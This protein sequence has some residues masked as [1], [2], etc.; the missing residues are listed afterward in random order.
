MLEFLELVKAPG[1]PIVV[2]DAPTLV[3]QATL[4][5]PVSTVPFEWLKSRCGVP[6]RYSPTDCLFSPGAMAALKT[7]IG[8]CC[9]PVAEE[10]RVKVLIDR[11]SARRRVTN[12]Q[13][14]VRYFSDK[15]Y[16]IAIPERMS[17]REQ[18]DLFSKASVIVGQT[19]AGLANMLFS[20]SGARIIV[21]SGH[22]EDPGPHNYFPNI[23]RTLG[24]EVQFMAFGPP[25]PNLHIDFK[26]DLA[27]LDQ[28]K[29]ML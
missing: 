7:R 26:V 10:D 19:G 12:R 11:N 18:M 9:P 24:H 16:V 22:P 17:L 28:F 27:F 25:S 5:T 2:I 23:A 3:E 21:L 13:E 8:E 4:F 6:V 1:R 14:L 15:G 20:P 29:E